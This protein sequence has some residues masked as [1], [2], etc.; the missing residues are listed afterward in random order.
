MWAALGGMGLRNSAANPVPFKRHRHDFGDFSIKGEPSVRAIF[1]DE[2]GTLW[3]ATRETL[4]PIDRLSKRYASY[5][6]GSPGED[7]DV[8]AICEDQFGSLWLGRLEATCRAVWA[9]E[10]GPPRRTNPTRTVKR[11]LAFEITYLLNLCAADYLA[12][13]LKRIP[14]CICRGLLAA[15]RSRKSGELMT[16]LGDRKLGVLRMSYPSMKSSSR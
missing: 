14:H 8:I 11:Q 6:I 4:N 9:K 3:I 7:S 13:K 15:D 16:A 1:E 10:K 2:N 5:R 12:L